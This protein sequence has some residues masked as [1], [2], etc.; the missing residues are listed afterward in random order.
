L[1]KGSSGPA[2]GVA[3]NNSLTI[4]QLLQARNGVLYNGD[5]KPV[6]VGTVVRSTC[7]TWLGRLAVTRRA[8][9]MGSLGGAGGALALMTPGDR[10]ASSLHPCTAA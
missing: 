1:L 6:E 4:L 7:Q 5:E 8:E 3:N 2:F 9:G 10:A